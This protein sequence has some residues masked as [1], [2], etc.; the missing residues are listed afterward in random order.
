MQPYHVVGQIS[1][2]NAVAQRSAE[3]CLNPVILLREAVLHRIDAVLRN[4]V[5]VRNGLHIVNQIAHLVRG[6]DLIRYLVDNVSKLSDICLLRL[7][8]NGIQN[9]TLP[10][11]TLVIPASGITDPAVC[12]RLQTVQRL[13]ARLGY[14]CVA[15]LAEFLR[16]CGLIIV[17]MRNLIL[18]YRNGNAAKSIHDIRQSAKSNRHEIR[19]IHIQ[20]L[21]EHVDRLLGPALCVSGIALVVCAITEVQQRITV[22]RNQLHVSGILIDG[23]DDNRIA[24]C[25]LI[26]LSL[27]GVHTEEG[28]VAVS[29]HL[30]LF[31]VL[32]YNIGDVVL[33]LFRRK[34][35]TLH[36]SDAGDK[37]K[38]QQ[39]S[40][41]NH[42]LNCDYRSPFFSS[43]G[44]STSPG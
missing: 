44:A 12:R 32:L 19:D 30:T 21:V 39:H 9:G 43:V 18:L 40:S 11:C 4:H 42:K 29:L 20:I 26:Q 37:I 7:V 28:D 33:D 38:N 25:I 2:N 16:H 31:C 1:R 8:H 6:V 23:A 41:K 36:L 15:V 17:Q 13:C 34:V 24:S 3:V 14:L 27:C 35:D 22:Y 5:I 10:R